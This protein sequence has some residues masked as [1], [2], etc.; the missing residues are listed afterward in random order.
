MFSD[1]SDE[2]AIRDGCLKYLRKIYS[3]VMIRAEY[4]ILFSYLS[5]ILQRHHV[6]F[7]GSQDERMTASHHY[8]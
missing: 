1:L 6:K 2:H 5:K 8:Y 3:L 4:D 7:T